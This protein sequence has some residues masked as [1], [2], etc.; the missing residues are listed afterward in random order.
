MLESIADSGFWLNESRRIRAGD[1]EVAIDHGLAADRRVR[2][3]HIPCL[4]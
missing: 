2:Y 1:P 3:V 4:T